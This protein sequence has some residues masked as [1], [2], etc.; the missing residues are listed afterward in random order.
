MCAHIVEVASQ[1]QESERSTGIV[2][3]ELEETR[4][5]RVDLELG[6]LFKTMRDKVHGIPF[7][8]E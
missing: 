8:K 2:R 7:S 5:Q 6:C 1:E 4:E 3:P